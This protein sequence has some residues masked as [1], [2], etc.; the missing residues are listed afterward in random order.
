[1]ALVHVRSH[2]SDKC[3]LGQLAVIVYTYGLLYDIRYFTVSLQEFKW[4]AA[5]MHIRSG[6]SDSC[7]SD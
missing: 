4:A 2:V 5:L 3:H 7:S 6:A 1:M